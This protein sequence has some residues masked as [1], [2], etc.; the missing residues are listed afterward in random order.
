M[1]SNIS[2]LTTYTRVNWEDKPSTNTPINA[3][4]LN[5]MD[6]AIYDNTAKTNEVIDGLD[7][8]F[9]SASNGKALVAS[10]ITGKGVSTA[11]NA[12]YATMAGNI[13]NQLMKIPTATYNIT[14]N[15]NYDVTNYKYAAVS[16]ANEVA[17][18]TFKHGT[19]HRNFIFRS[20]ERYYQTSSAGSGQNTLTSKY[21]RVS[22]NYNADVSTSSVTILQNGYYL[23]STVGYVRYLP[24]GTVLSVSS[25]D[26]TIKDLV[27]ARY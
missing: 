20:D 2:K 19:W 1:S 5:T 6:K 8:C 25:S 3:T 14:Q 13:T 7:E 10:A 26:T 17:I 12:S 4:N 23:D 11:S 16:T 24:A 27:V 9:Q 15:G 22:H 18:S 21:F